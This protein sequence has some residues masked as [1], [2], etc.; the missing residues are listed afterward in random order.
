MVINGG[1]YNLTDDEI[2]K[3]SKNLLSKLGLEKDVNR[4]VNEYSL[5]MK[6][7]LA[8]SIAL[9]KEPELLVLDEPTSGLDTRG[10]KALRIVLKD[11]NKKGLTILLS[12]HVLSEVQ[13]IC[14]HVGIINKGKIIRQESIKEI[15]KEIEK[16]TIKLLLKVKN[17]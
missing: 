4:K 2:K 17:I 7:R 11:L 10:V 9:I 5:G 15:T 16:K 8:L 13:E 3:R 6:K 1:F 12:S 14:T